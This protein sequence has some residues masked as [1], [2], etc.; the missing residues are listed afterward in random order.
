V[1][2]FGTDRQLGFGYWRSR[3]S[4]DGC[5]SCLSYYTDRSGSGCGLCVFS[6]CSAGHELYA[7]WWSSEDDRLVTRE[8]SR[9]FNGTAMD[10]LASCSFLVAT[11]HVSGS[12]SAR[13][14]SGLT[15]R[16]CQVS[17]P[18]P[19]LIFCV[20]TCSLFLSFFPSDRFPFASTRASVCY[21]PPFLKSSCSCCLL[22]PRRWW[23][24][25]RTVAPHPIPH[26]WLGP[27]GGSASRQP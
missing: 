5:A 25:P 6:C 15:S 19:C 18:R 7:L 23:W 21:S 14:S 17:S 24:C 11:T 22:P 27:G 20:E 12:F 26:S 9:A 16:F 8:E 3:I 13:F 1:C 2:L 4:M 10:G